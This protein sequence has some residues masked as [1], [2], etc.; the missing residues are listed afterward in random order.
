MRHGN[1]EI[2]VFGAVFVF[3][4]RECVITRHVKRSF[5]LALTMS[6]DLFANLTNFL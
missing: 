3:T 4:L 6:I 1:Y 5:L 2:T